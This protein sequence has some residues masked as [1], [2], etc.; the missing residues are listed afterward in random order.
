MK[1]VRLVYDI[2]H[3]RSVMLVTGLALAAIAVNTWLYRPELLFMPRVWAVVAMSGAI[4]AFIG[5]WK[6]YRP[7]VVW[8]GAAAVFSCVTRAFAILYELLSAEDF[9]SSTQAS[10]RVQGIL[11]ALTGMLL[12]TVWVRHILVWRVHQPQ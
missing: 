3:P 1:D 6:P 7:W 5:T 12:F 2:T 10:L 9:D 8:A 4:G 11:F